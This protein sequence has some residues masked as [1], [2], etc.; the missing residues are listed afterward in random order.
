MHLS[1][2][3]KLEH[4]QDQIEQP[5]ISNIRTQI[6]LSNR[7]GKSS[8]FEAFESIERGEQLSSIDGPRYSVAMF[9]YSNLAQVC[10]S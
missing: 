7:K 3:E 4:V 6:I 1:Q 5:Y 2:I 8:I 10:E 9:K